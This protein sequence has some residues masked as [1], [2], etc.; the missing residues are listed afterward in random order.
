MNRPKNANTIVGGIEA[1]QGLAG[2]ITALP[3]GVLADKYGR[4]PMC[5]IGGAGFML[6]GV[7]T[8]VAIYM[9][10]DGETAKQELT[11][12]TA[13][14]ICWGIFGGVFSGPVQALFADSVPKGE[15]SRY[16][17]ILSNVY[18]AP[19]LVGPMIA[20]YL[21]QKYGDNWTFEELKT[22]FVFGV[23]LELPAALV[24]FF[25]K[26]EHALDEEEEEDKKSESDKVFEQKP[27]PSQS[28][29]CG[30]T[31]TK[32]SIPYVMLTSDILFAL[33]SGMTIKFFP[34]FFM[35]EV[36][37]S[38]S[39]VQVISILSRLLL[40]MFTTVA[41][42]LSV[43]TGRV[44]IITMARLLGIAFLVLI[45]FLVDYHHY[46]RP[47]IVILYLFRTALMNCTYPL[48][49]SILMDNVKKDERSKWKSLESVTVFGWTGS[50]FIGGILADKFS[51]GFSFLITAAF[52][53]VGALVYLF[54]LPIVTDE[55]KKPVIQ[56]E[57]S[58]VEEAD[59][60]LNADNKEE[61]DK[62]LMKPLLQDE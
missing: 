3:I 22:P 19:S 42:K 55:V 40:M 61:V 18:F 49:E 39:V 51:Y 36:K 1:A 59:I 24:V 28:V 47:V 35:N 31:L 48:D 29:V 50:A 16:Y 20:I 5:K 30:K 25:L 17:T 56:N 10:D 4:A 54:L 7:L 37:L 2:L 46:T 11:I 43:H 41:Q 14:L 9:H 45:S 52:Q 57:A 21:F 32:E 60:E 23:V 8:L 15:R 34:L 62:Q 53:L 44:Q 38:P 33:G 12:M 6:A 13:A 58:S 26:D 27:Q